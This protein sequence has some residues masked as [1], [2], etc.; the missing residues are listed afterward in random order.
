LFIIVII[1]I[2]III[3]IIISL[4]YFTRN[5]GTELF[6]KAQLARQ[7]FVLGLVTDSR[8]GEGAAVPPIDWT[9]FKT[10]E[11]FARKCIIFAQNF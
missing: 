11:N 2:I 5:A 4:I 7:K 8:K 10:S 3:V 9:H 6:M 1:I